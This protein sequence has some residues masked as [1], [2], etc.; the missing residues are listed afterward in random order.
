MLTDREEDA[1][2]EAF[3]N[4]S[5]ILRINPGVSLNRGNKE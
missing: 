1:L 4:E 2:W 3:C 5:D